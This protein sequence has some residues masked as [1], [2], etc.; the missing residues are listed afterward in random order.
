VAIGKAMKSLDYVILLLGVG[1]IALAIAEWMDVVS[2]RLDP[3]LLVLLGLALIGR[4][5]LRLKMQGRER[6]R[7]MMLREI[8]K[9][10]LGI[11]EEDRGS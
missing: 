3:R 4:V 2:H 1:S 8:P 10:P 5:V 7:Q 9:K 11:E 6:Q